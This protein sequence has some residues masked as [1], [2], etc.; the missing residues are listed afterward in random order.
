MFCDAAQC[1][2]IAQGYFASAL[3]HPAAALEFLELARDDF[4]RAAQFRGK[5][6]V[7]CSDLIIDGKFN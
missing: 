7:R 3:G 1:D 4:T 5:P 2:L 6:L